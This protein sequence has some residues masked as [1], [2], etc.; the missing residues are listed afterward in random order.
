VNL[1]PV[2]LAKP[3]L[4]IH[5]P[6]VIVVHLVGVRVLIYRRKAT[7]SLRARNCAHQ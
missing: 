4:T 7:A 6:D 5:R 2:P 1:H 3:A